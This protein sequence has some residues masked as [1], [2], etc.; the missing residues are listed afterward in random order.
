MRD[1]ERDEMRE[2]KRK[3]YKTIT[4]DLSKE[5]RTKITKIITVKIEDYHQSRAR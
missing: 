2:K 3:M 5:T 1:I 4:E